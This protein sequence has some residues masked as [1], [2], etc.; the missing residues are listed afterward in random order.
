MISCGSGGVVVVV[1]LVDV[2]VEGAE[3]AQID[4]RNAV[5]IVVGIV[6]GGQAC[7]KMSRIKSQPAHKI[8]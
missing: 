3:E 1:G 4:V 6:K 8:C 5:R 2:S 7:K